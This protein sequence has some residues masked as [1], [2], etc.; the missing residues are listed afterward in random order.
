[1]YLSRLIL[2]PRYAPGPSELA[3]PYEMHRSHHDGLPGRPEPGEERVLFRVD[4]RPRTA[5][6]TLLVQSCDVPDWSWLAEERVRAAICCRWPEP[7]PAVKPFDLHSVAGTNARR[8]VC[9]QTRLSRRKREGR[10]RT[11]GLLDEDEQISWL[12]RK[13]E[14]GGFQR[15]LGQ[16]RRRGQDRRRHP[17]HKRRDRQDGNA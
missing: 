6:S 15:P 7:N 10:P 16:Q 9:G 14:A 1:M 2:N 4:E 5:G 17:S 12:V 3:E 11:Q 8:S 13:A